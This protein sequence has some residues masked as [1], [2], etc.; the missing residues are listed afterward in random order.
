[1]QVCNECIIL[2]AFVKNCR[3]TNGRSSGTIR[4]WLE[5]HIKRLYFKSNKHT[6]EQREECLFEKF[7]DCLHQQIANGTIFFFLKNG[8]LFH[9]VG[10]LEME[11]VGSRTLGY[12]FVN[13]FKNTA[14]CPHKTDYCGDCF[15]F[16]TSM[17]SLQQKMNLHKVSLHTFFSA[18]CNLHT[19]L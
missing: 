4:F 3:V 1:M 9:C 8:W 2:Q 18:R 15:D 16:K 5:S 10:L 7:Q 17:K 19:V 14:V 11:K 12:W 13:K 6:A